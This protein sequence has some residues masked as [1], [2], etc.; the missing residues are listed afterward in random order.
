MVDLSDVYVVLTPNRQPLSSGF[1]SYLPIR[2]Q[3]ASAVSV[4]YEKYEAK[5]LKKPFSTR[6]IDYPDIGFATQGDCYETCL[7]NKVLEATNGTFIS[8]SNELDLNETRKI[9]THMDIERNM[10]IPGLS[11]GVESLMNRLDEYCESKCSNED[12]RSVTFIPK[13]LGRTQLN[14]LAVL[15]IV[16]PQSPTIRSK[17]RQAVTIIQ[18]LTDV[19]SAFGFWLGVSAV[20]LWKVVSVSGTIVIKTGKGIDM[21]S[22]KLWRK[23]RVNQMTSFIASSKLL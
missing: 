5:R 2:L 12:C 22:V 21:P 6:C 3:A 1:L 17:C 13:K 9:I 23:K 18:F 7:D 14:T 4:T 15:A 8:P 16:A 11:E 19:F 20:G 10:H